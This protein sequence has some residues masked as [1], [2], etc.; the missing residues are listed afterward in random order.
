MRL[1]FDHGPQLVTRGP[2]GAEAVVM[3]TREDDKRLIAPTDL[4]FAMRQFP[5]AKAVA[6]GLFD[7]HR[8]C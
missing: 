7:E 5:L 3:V 1:A 6:E 4:Y 8:G 2:S